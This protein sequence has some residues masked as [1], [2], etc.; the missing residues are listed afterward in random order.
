MKLKYLLSIMILILFAACKKDNY[1]VPGI[2]LKGHVV[3]RGEAI[4]VEQ[5]FDNP[6]NIELWQPGFGKLAAIPLPIA[7]DGAFSQA[8]FNGQYKLT[9]Q[10]GTGPW[11]WKTNAQGKPDTLYID[12]KGD[13]TMDVEVTPY[14]MIRNPKFNLSAGK[15]K[16]VFDLE[17]IITDA[18]G[19]DIQSVTLYLNKTQFV[20]GAYSIASTTSQP[21][22]NLNGITLEVNVPTL[23][24]AQNY[25]FARIG[26]TIAGVN[27]LLFSPVQKLTF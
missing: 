16:V 22:I 25:V 23:T 12:L 27:R 10:N 5:S 13:Q 17:K 9:M 3:Y 24:P 11:M 21:V 2:T 4:N 20:S 15:V 8:L 18:N 7:Q 6:S 1:E 14:Y 26:V 19:K